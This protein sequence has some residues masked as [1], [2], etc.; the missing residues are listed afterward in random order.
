[1][2]HHVPLYSP[3]LLSLSGLSMPPLLW[4][5][6][7]PIQVGLR[8]PHLGTSACWPCWVLWTVS[9]VFCTS[10]GWGG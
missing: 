9:W 2:P 7:S 3:C 4:L 5:L 6:S 10:F 1:V 8:H